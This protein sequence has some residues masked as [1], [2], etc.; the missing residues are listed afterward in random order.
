MKITATTDKI[1]NKILYELAKYQYERYF[2]Y[3]I[4]KIFNIHKII[5]IID[6]NLNIG[7]NKQIT[8]NNK[9]AKIIKCLMLLK[10]NINSILIL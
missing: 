10:L 2:L 6:I 7:I 3:K 9:N 5:K 8:K 1:T 4:I